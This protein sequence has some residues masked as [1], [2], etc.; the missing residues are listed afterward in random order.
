MPVTPPNS[1]GSLSSSTSEQS[2]QTPY[3][4][5]S[6]YS[7]QN[8][9]IDHSPLNGYS[10]GNNPASYV[11]FPSSGPVPIQT[12]HEYPRL[13]PYMHDALER[14]RFAYL[15]SQYPTIPWAIPAVYTAKT[16]LKT[17]EESLQNPL[18]IKN[19]Y[20]RGLAPGT[21]DDL[22]F[23][24]AKFNTFM[25]AELCIRG[26]YL[27]NY[28]VGFARE[29]NS[30]FFGYDIESSRILRDTHGNSRGVGFARF[31]SR[32]KSDEVIKL[33][34][35]QPVGREGL[36]LQVRYADTEEQKK[37]KDETV[38]RRN[39]RA[40]EYTA[41]ARS[42]GH[43][44]EYAAMT[45]SVGHSPEHVPGLGA[46]RSAA[47]SGRV[48]NEMLLGDLPLVEYLVHRILTVMS[49]RIPVNRALD[50]LR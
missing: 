45:L 14:Q 40:T 38:R 5:L 35:G 37:L 29:L 34:H 8:S 33:F 46:W 4:G 17:L 15:L 30:I 3:H 19:V 47:T 27:R 50:A 25:E 31:T 43:V 7:T 44:T 6:A 16:S 21:T 26:F 24:F 41:S 13:E 11:A 18:R 49:M 48:Q 23:G 1:A 12:H 42:V 10:Y 22:L 2:P 9:S 28:E 36:L 39:F 20:I 32:S